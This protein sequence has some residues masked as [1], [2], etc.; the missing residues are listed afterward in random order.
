MP[1]QAILPVQTVLSVLSVLHS[2]TVLR[3]L[4]ILIIQVV[5]CTLVAFR[6]FRSRYRS[7]FRSR[8]RSGCR[9]GYF[10]GLI[11]CRLGFGPQIQSGKDG[12]SAEN[13]SDHAQDDS[14]GSQLL[15]LG[16]RLVFRSLSHITHPAR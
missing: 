15:Q 5:L 2:Q 12:G 8:F 10:C 9:R 6:F 1:V 13:K 4:P 3:I 16:I 7:R 14:H 11:Y